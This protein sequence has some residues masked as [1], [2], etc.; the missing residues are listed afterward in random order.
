MRCKESEWQ[1]QVMVKPRINGQMLPE[2]G[3][4]MDPEKRTLEC[5]V[6]VREPG[7]F[8]FKV[9][10]KGVPMH[11][12][13]IGLTIDDV[14]RGYWVLSSTKTSFENE[15]HL[16]S[17][18]DCQRPKK[19]KQPRTK[20]RWPVRAR[21]YPDTLPSQM[22]ADVR[23]DCK[24]P[25]PG[26]IEV[27]VWLWTR[28]QGFTLPR[29][30]YSLLDTDVDKTSKVEETAGP[31][32]THFIRMQLKQVKLAQPHR[33]FLGVGEGVKP[34]DP[35]WMTFRFLYRSQGRQGCTPQNELP[36]LTIMQRR[37]NCTTRPRRCVR[38]DWLLWNHMFGHLVNT[39]HWN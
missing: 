8:T 16:I 32:A 1:G 4:T 30:I 20:K 13:C 18:V 26:C 33:S 28:P 19:G 9:E 17:H 24:V 31:R 21:M 38:S 34:Q 5:F 29:R 6:P 3:Q 11:A 25:R 39:S 23:Q 14:V 7:A 12:Y 36:V 2:F 37:W 27:A 15:H 22:K 10:F 35:A